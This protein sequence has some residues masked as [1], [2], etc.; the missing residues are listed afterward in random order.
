MP[1]E[2]D[3]SEPGL[4]EAK[5][6]QQDPGSHV[7]QLA[8]EHTVVALAGEGYALLHY[9]KALEAFLR[10]AHRTFI[11]Q[12]QEEAI[13]SSH[14]AEWVLENFHIIQQALRQ[15]SEDL[16]RR[17]YRELPELDAGSWAG[18]PRAYVVARV[19]I[20][21]ETARFSP[22]PLQD[23]VST[24]QEVQPLTTGELWAL[25]I[26]LRIG[27]LETLVYA[28]ASTLDEK[29]PA[30]DPPVVVSIELRAETLV[31]NCILSLRAIANQ[32]WKDFFESVSL[33]E[34]T[35]G[36]D[37]ACVYRQMDFDTRDRYRKVVEKVAKA[38]PHNERDVA[39]A[40]IQLASQQPSARHGEQPTAWQ[41]H[42]GYYL[43]DDGRSVL[44]AELNYRPPTAARLHRWLI[45]GHPTLVYVGSIGFL[46]L[47]LLLVLLGYAA[48]AEAG[49]GQ[50][51]VTAVLLL[52]PV[53]T[54]AT[55]L[56][57]PLVPVL[58][59][60]RL[61]PKMDFEDGVPGRARTM[62][63]VP[64]LVASEDDVESLLDQLMLHYLRNT[65]PHIT[66]A[67]L[68][69]FADAP[70]EHEPE[71]EALLQ[72]VKGGV[73]A[74]NE[75]YPGNPFYLFHRKR[76]WNPQE[77]VW[78]GWER[79]RGKLEE[80]NRLQR[81]EGDTTYVVK[82][83]D[84]SVLPD[85]RYV[86]TLDADTLLPTGA[87]H[88]LIG[89]L[90]H[91]LNRAR[92]DPD[93]GR[94]VA[95]YTVL[96]PR[97]EVKPV[98]AGLS[99]FTRI[100]SN[101]SG[102]DLYTHAVSDV[103]QDLF[104]EGIYVGKGIYD[105]ASF[106]SSLEDRVPENALLSHDLFEGI[107]G[108]AGLVTDIILY[109]DYPPG[110]LAYARRQHRWIRGDWQLLPWLL[111]S[112]PHRERGL[113]P[114][115]L[116]FIDRW[117]IVDNLRRSLMAPALL[118]LL[119]AGWLW[120][121]GSP[122]VWTLV[123]MI[124]PAGSLLNGLV[125]NLIRQ[126]KHGDAGNTLN[127]VLLG[128]IIRWLLYFVFLP[129][130]ALTALNA[131]ITVFA[132]LFFTGKRLLQWTTAAHTASLFDG[133]SK[134]DL[135]WR[136][137]VG[138]SLLGLALGG[139][140]LWRNVAALPVALP[141]LLS[142]IFSPQIA[143]WLSQPIE[144]RPARLRPEQ[145][146]QLRGLARSTWLY[147]EQFTGP[148][149]H[150]L[151]PDH[152]QEHPR[153]QV[154]HRTS[155]TNIGLAL[156]STLA[157]YDFGYMGMLELALRLQNSF[158]TLLALERHRGHFLN[159]Y[160][161]QTRMP[162]PPRYVSSVDS[163][164]LAAC[165]MTLR[166][167]CLAMP[168]VTLP[169]WQR[170]QGLLDTLDMLVEVLQDAEPQ[171]PEIVSTLLGQIGRIR[172]RI[173]DASGDPGSWTILLVSLAEEAWPQLEDRVVDLIETYHLSPDLLRRIRIW[174]ERSRHNLFD[175]QRRL[176][177]LIPWLIA[178][179]N[180]PA[181]FQDAPA[182]AVFAQ[183]WEALL[184][185]LPPEARVG[186]IAAICSDAR[187]RLMTLR[188]QLDHVEAPAGDVDAARQWCDNLAQK[189]DEAVEVVTGLLDI[190]HSV[191][192]QSEQLVRDMAFDFL[193]DPQRRVFRIGYNVDAG[194]PDPNCYD[195]LASEA[196]NT[197]LIAIAKQEV[198]QRHWLNLGRPLM[199]VDGSRCLVSWSGTMFE[200]LMPILWTRQYEH[201]LLGESAYAAVRTQM[202][203]ARQKGVPWGMS[204]S[205]YYR[206]DAAMNYQY[207]A[208]GVPQLGFKRGLDEDTVIAPYASLLALSLSP[209][210]VMENIQRLREL[211]MWGDYGFYEAIDYTSERLALGQDYARVLSYMVHHQAMILLSL[212]NAL[213]EEVM[214][215]RF[216]ADP[217]VQSVE[218]LLQERIPQEVPL[219]ELAASE[220]EALRPAEREV[221]AK[222][223]SVPL[224]TLWPQA[225]Y[226]SN[227]RYEV[228][229]TNAGSGYSRWQDIDLTRWRA[230]TTCDDWGTWIYVQDQDSTE[231]WSVGSQPIAGEGRNRE[232]TFAPD[233]VDIRCHGQDIAIHTE[234]TVPPEDDLE[235]RRVRL[236]NQGDET[237][238]LRLVSYGEVVLAQQDAD[239]R[240]PAFNKMFIESEYRAQSHTLIFTRRPRSSEEMP[241]VMVHALV[242]EPDR[243]WTGGYETDRERF[244]GRGGTPLA[245]TAMAPAGNG[246]SGTTGAVLDPI[247]SLAVDI[248]VAPHTTASVA[249][250][251]LAG[252]NRDAVLN[253]ARDYQDWAR[254]DRAFRQAHSQSELEMRQ[255][256]LDVEDLQRFQ[257]LLSLLLYPHRALRPEPEVLAANE[258]GQPGL[259]P[260]AISGD[261]PILMVQIYGEEDLGLVHEMLQAHIY[262]RNRGL[263]IDLVLM[264]EQ[265]S[266]YAQELPGQLR[267]LVQRMN[268]DHL[269]D[270]RG[271]IFLL[272]REAMSAADQVLL[273][274]TARAVLDAKRGPLA[275]HLHDV[276]QQPAHLPALI[277]TR[278]S[279]G[280]PERPPVARPD[281]L[282]F[283]NGWGG[284]SSDG[285]EY[286][287]HLAPG[288]RTPAPWVNVIAN[289]TF[290]FLVSE[291]GG[292]YT[293]AANSGE[294]RLTPWRNDPVRDAPGEALYLR[295]E[296]TAEIW[297]PTVAPAG[298]NT[299]HLVRHGAGYSIFESHAHGLRQRL[300]LF[301]ACDAP[302]KIVRLRLENTWDH[303]RRITATYYAEWVLGVNRDT[304]QQYV[305]PEYDQDHNALLASNPY[306]ADFGERV[307]FLAAS[308]QPHGL[309]TDRTEFLGRLGNEAQPAG[310]K[311]IGLTSTVQPGLDPCAALQLHVELDPGEA[312]E[313]WFLL[314]QG[315]NRDE[316][317]QL[318]QRFQGAEAVGMAWDEAVRGWDELLGMVTVDT[319][320]GAMNTLLNRWLPYQVLSC[321]IWGRSALYQSSGGF[322]FR[323]QLQDVA[324]LLHHAPDL[325]R[326][327]ILR[328]ARHQFEAGDVLHW[329]H[330]PYG[331]GVRTRNSD[332]LLW[333][334]Y[335]A[336]HYVRVTGDESI[337]CE[338][339][340]F[341][342]GDPLQAHEVE[343]YGHY[344]VSEETGTLYEHC[345]RA[346]EKGT[347]AGPHSLPLI[348]TG[349]W[350]DGMNRV[351]IEGRG[352]SVWLG[353]FLYA[354]LDNYVPICERMEDEVRARKFRERM[355][356]L[357]E[358]L[359]ASA[360]DGNW[361]LRGFYDDG[362]P[363]G[364]VKAKE[365]QIDSIA[366]SWAVLSGAGDP[367]RNRQAM[368]SVAERLVR[369]DD[370]LL[371]LLT[372]PFDKTSK[373]PGYIK[374]Y[375]PGVRENG[376]QYT[377]AA[378][379][380]V[381]A[382][383]EMGDGNRAEALFRLLNPITH[384]DTRAKAQRY[385]LEPYVTAADVYSMKPFTGRGGWSWYTGSSGWL[386]RLGLEAILGLR[387]E[388]EILRIKPCIPR[389]W[390]GYTITHR[391]GD[392]IYH[393]RVENPDR[394]NRGVREV[395]LDGESLAAGAISLKDDGARH[396]ITVRMG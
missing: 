77:E 282:R 128:Q 273:A 189:L 346:L 283:D 309:T 363:L 37:P 268:S 335:V 129:H 62:V 154:A 212:V 36:Q 157:A 223:W 136:E 334:P 134:L 162:L 95:G 376:G 385:R 150:W 354:C 316:A 382:F 3:R 252:D 185:V 15:I 349:D 395:I 359:A 281:S 175:M 18:Y 123:A 16:P 140:I 177:A 375:P 391:Y 84:L 118:A 178:L 5:T 121:P 232:V 286:I 133:R 367:Q 142:W 210:A 198:P 197:S 108:R 41:Q 311:R 70:E 266:G 287:I 153:G 196:R 239:R 221:T 259:W 97:T 106:H 12:A 126:V 300:Q 323:D 59:P 148:A 43:I 180:P 357:E 21:Q 184:A 306:N 227:G 291:M 371:L 255:L 147:F 64:G 14:T 58:V 344:E 200:Y 171:A 355:A 289:P 68:T 168:D 33:V 87:A 179:N 190:Y 192:E 214:V 243:E 361:Y 138:A 320:D 75:R 370:R 141:F 329:W 124:A 312:K 313:I 199:Q 105:V 207:R 250:L 204:E 182:R 113:V 201:T 188:Q 271:G 279:N 310:L 384:S 66:F 88:R 83:G 317:L 374:G 54:L 137:M 262:W 191:S 74:L 288:E 260:Y 144:R 321:R 174:T 28:I 152:F 158:Q 183:A 378:I 57:N 50:L 362:S 160:D 94:V 109:E 347:T 10:R 34:R 394:V 276:W 187:P 396:N 48:S 386:Y 368:A 217:R 373:D 22:T 167:G 45:Q 11:H 55:S 2:S 98:S 181:L 234:I 156:L 127:Q 235:I 151:P 79:K 194:Q 32:D 220:S 26:M 166:Q 263:R 39:R 377:H 93:T 352:E 379:W 176:N 324:A 145:E 90:D 30:G 163:G 161:T 80:F 173:L 73:R 343:R 336:A 331:R 120:L 325:A 261:Y 96:Q 353:W 69:D 195:L 40:A 155:P 209:Q 206:F 164:N 119:V 29:A 208:F 131:V 365:C 338:R 389:E 56:V 388:G 82:L 112:V 237:R 231:L 307:A 242:V 351:G 256:E 318:V 52:I 284:F 285:R 245:P 238:R 294:N 297:T 267:R 277:P 60:P 244:L 193:Y 356:A 218:L 339:I 345:C 169:R 202:A 358:A 360:W 186:D 165:L 290:G 17:Y 380:A 302:V 107:H 303:V 299:S 348:G 275:A 219:E 274:T 265:A 296:E 203:Y 111:P 101:A 222:P 122:L 350:N 251:T 53:V 92:I 332:D 19:F 272:R 31:G 253:L 91:P 390:T 67:L 314:G 205:G 7:L 116:T 114:N 125:A 308:Q 71:D 159:W 38:T 366:Q 139:L 20:K 99:R 216:H 257:Q 146:R 328:A 228:L 333:L 393:I 85:I 130:E 230:D 246:L 269:L 224:E 381:W 341:R 103:Y 143:L 392:A 304:M 295:D 1:P 6:A 301:A 229:I 117:K 104:G 72:R 372:P 9:L 86:I 89:T 236:I 247:M 258:K 249:F 280:R 319:P 248:E 63:V 298:A 292:G 337:L 225:N 100:F 24:Y 42:V 305:L 340:P 278:D 327:H 364:S 102:L 8:A 226:L 13:L 270:Q 172:Q 115:P 240:H 326:Q 211:D 78:M 293:W 135:T 342:Q 132:R 315:E 61:L 65:D 51:A 369:G 23:F 170:W 49:L 387:R 44:E 254:I 76:L 25:P 241:P 322:G 264:N 233:K 4:A 110:Y 215:Q 46:T 383:A 47:I 149:D 213:E 27:I 81:G 330:P 35:L